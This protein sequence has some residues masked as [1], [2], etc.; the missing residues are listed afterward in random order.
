M[1]TPQTHLSCCVYRR[2]TGSR[3]LPQTKSQYSQ[4]NN[5]DNY[6]YNDNSS[7]NNIDAG[8][9]RYFST[10]GCW[11]SGSSVLQS[12]L[13]SP[14]AVS[15]LTLDKFLF[16]ARRTSANTCGALPRRLKLTFSWKVPTDRWPVLPNIVDVF[17]NGNRMQFSK[18]KNQHQ[19]KE[20]GELG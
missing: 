14:T 6:K 11:E 18:K 7:S 2:I 3:L 8:T 15:V 12:P 1:V 4:G 13:H 9:C 19:A 10:V 5:H 20:C 17:S 16:R